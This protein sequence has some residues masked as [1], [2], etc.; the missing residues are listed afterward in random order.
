MAL[1]PV[2]G[3]DPRFR[4]SL[5]PETV[6]VHE[7]ILSSPGMTP[8]QQQRKFNVYKV[9]NETFDTSANPLVLRMLSEHTGGECFEPDQADAWMAALKR[10]YQ[11]QQLPPRREYI[12]DHWTV[13]AAL[14]SWM[15]L[16]WLLRRRVGL[17]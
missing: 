7:V 3:R 5:E 15:G 17:L 6:G 2:A 10:Q 9:E 1:G 16:E 8:A 14:L 13:M 11:S 4:A 12:W